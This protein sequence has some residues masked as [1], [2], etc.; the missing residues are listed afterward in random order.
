ML[1]LIIKS[2][3]RLKPLITATS[4]TLVKCLKYQFK[5]IMKNILMLFRPYIFTA[6]IDQKA[7][8]DRNNMQ[9]NMGSLYQMAMVG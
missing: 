9:I 7:I 3:H 5:M 6:K 8:V 2:D 4:I 1:L